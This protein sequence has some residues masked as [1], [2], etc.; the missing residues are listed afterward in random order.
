MEDV[1]AVPVG[2]ASELISEQLRASAL[3]Q[4]RTSALDTCDGLTTADVE[5]IETA[6]S[7]PVLRE[8][9][10]ILVEVCK[11]GQSGAVGCVKT[12][13]LGV[14]QLAFTLDSLN[15][16][17]GRGERRVGREMAVSV[18]AENVGLVARSGVFKS[19]K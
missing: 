3:L 4:V 18:Q 9:R 17:V 8:V 14:D 19:G 7:W 6:E 1:R 5:L 2:T 15:V 16:N 13:T 11:C 12:R 10:E